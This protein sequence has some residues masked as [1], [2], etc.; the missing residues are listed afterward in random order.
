MHKKVRNYI[1]NWF[2]ILLSKVY[3]YIFVI[4]L[5]RYLSRKQENFE[6]VVNPWH[7]NKMNNLNVYES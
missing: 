2:F 4:P 6:L 1:Q 5:L 7:F 3:L